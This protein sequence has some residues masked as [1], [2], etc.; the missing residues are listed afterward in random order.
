LFHPTLSV[1]KDID[2]DRGTYAA[3]SVGHNWQFKDVG[4]SAT[5]TGAWNHNHYREGSGITHVEVEG[6]MALPVTKGVTFNAGVMKQYSL[7]DAVEDATVGSV[8]LQW[9]FGGN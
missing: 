3:L 8:S 2:E 1:V 6:G 5:L 7:S 9:D 4:L